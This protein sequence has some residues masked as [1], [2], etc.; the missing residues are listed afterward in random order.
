MWWGLSRGIISYAAPAPCVGKLLVLSIPAID[1]GGKTCRVFP[2][3]IVF[4]EV[5]DDARA[6][7]G[8]K[9]NGKDD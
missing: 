8:G 7:V 5:E 1:R 9:R 2:S 3:G 6:N 4:V